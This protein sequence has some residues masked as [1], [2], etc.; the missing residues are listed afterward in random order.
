MAQRMA[1]VNI[2]SSDFKNRVSNKKVNYIQEVADSEDEQDQGA[3]QAEI[4]LAEWAR[5]Q[6]GTIILPIGN[7]QTESFSFDINKADRIFD[8]LLKEKWIKLSP[9]HTIPSPAELKKQ[10]YY[11]WHNSVSH[12]TNDCNVFRR[13]IQL[14][15]EQGRLKID[16]AQKAM[17]I[18]GHPFP[19]IN[20]VNV[21]QKGKG[22][23][24]ESEVPDRQSSA[25]KKKV[26]L[27]TGRSSH[28][29]K[30][31][32]HQMLLSKYKAQQERAMR[33]QERE[34]R[35]IREERR[36]HHENMR[37]TDGGSSHR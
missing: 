29:P 20:M 22:K 23:A 25:P 12:N 32:T 15:I 36:C 14:A 6:K 10:K 37:R 30:K 28:G 17:A 33:L 35:Q 8:I 4:D 11:K 26:P 24:D 18:D 13:E 7:K 34:S 9:N 19:T 1:T 2:K 31:V 21:E 3:P 16:G 27:E 5:D